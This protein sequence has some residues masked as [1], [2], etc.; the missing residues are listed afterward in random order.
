VRTLEVVLTLAM[1]VLAPRSLRPQRRPIPA[2]DGADAAF[3]DRA[4]LSQQRAALIASLWPET[5]PCVVAARYEQ[6]PVP[7]LFGAVFRVSWR[8]P[9]DDRRFAAG[10]P[11][12]EGECRV[13]HA[14][15]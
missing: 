13:A 1:R 14:S 5:R 7:A 15:A 12:A 6:L 10:F 8:A 4:A 2:V 11:H 9:S 3:L